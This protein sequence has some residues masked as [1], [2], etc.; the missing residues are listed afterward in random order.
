M[1]YL[2]K[3]LEVAGEQRGF[4]TVRDGEG[5]GVPAIE[6]RKMA[7]RGVLVRSGHGLYRIVSFSA[8]RHD[9][10]KAA[11]LWADGEGVTSHESALSLWELCDVNPRMINVTVPRRMRRAG[12]S[13]YRLWLNTLDRFDIDW[14]VRA[15]GSRLR[16]GRSLMRSTREPE[17]HSSSKRSSPRCGT[18]SWTSE[19]RRI[20]GTD[21]RSCTADIRKPGRGRVSYPT[22]C[23]SGSLARR[24]D[25][26]L[27]P[28]GSSC[29]SRG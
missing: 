23:R 6:L 11:N 17:A 9:E 18:G 3:L 25:S 20:F 28:S 21:S 22:R 14:R 19:T 4:V 2:A 15:F 26:A 8:Q 12:P 7:S 29:P 1:S 13:Y 16:L 27:D 10:Y 24:C 5:V